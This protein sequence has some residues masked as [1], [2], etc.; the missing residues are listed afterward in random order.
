MFRERKKTLKDTVI[1]LLYNIFEIRFTLIKKICLNHV[2]YG[3]ICVS[4][5]LEYI[6]IAL[7]QSHSPPH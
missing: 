7:H 3:V 1:Q 4:I 6:H 5:L 2:T